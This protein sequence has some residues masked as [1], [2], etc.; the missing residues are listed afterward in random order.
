MRYWIFTYILVTFLGSLGFGDGRDRFDA[1]P[2]SL[3]QVYKP[4]ART[5]VDRGQV[6]LVDWLYTFV[7]AGIFLLL[8]KSLPGKIG[9]V[10]GISYGVIVWFCRVV[11]DVGSQWVFFDVPGTA[12]VYTLFV[13]LLQMVVL[14][15][16]FGLLLDPIPTRS[17]PN[18]VT[19]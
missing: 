13:G 19:S 10:Q 1:N 15:A 4:F 14:G 9:F 7:L 2:L 16:F 5:A 3:F 6:L 17:H 8:F 11:V 12:L 18:E